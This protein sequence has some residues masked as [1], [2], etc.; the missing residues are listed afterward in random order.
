MRLADLFS[1]A[2]F[3]LTTLTYV[4]S[5]D[6]QQ[7]ADP[8]GI[9]KDI[10]KI[11]KVNKGPI[12]IGGPGFGPLM[13]GWQKGDVKDKDVLS[14]ANFAA[15]AL[16]PAL[17]PAPIVRS[18]AVQVVAGLNYNITMDVTRISKVGSSATVCSV[19][20][21]VVWNHFG[22]FSVMANSTVPSTR[23]GN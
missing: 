16:F 18:V 21:C 9:E 3:V 4:A 7:P 13:G 12:R 15:E 1:I 2:L 10:T 20:N 5:K 23:C 17:H 19:Y 6:L 11:L 22:V 8:N 14:A